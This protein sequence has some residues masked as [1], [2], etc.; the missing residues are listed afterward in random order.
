MS[1]KY[2]SN[3]YSICKD[4]ENVGVYVAEQHLKNL[5]QD[6]NNIFKI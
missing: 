4:A 3:T 6:E 5:G 2:N 1:N